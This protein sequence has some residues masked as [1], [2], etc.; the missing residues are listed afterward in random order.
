MAEQESIIDIFTEKRKAALDSCQR[1]E[2]EMNEFKNNRDSKLKDIE[3][4]NEL[5]KKPI[6]FINVNFTLFLCRNR[7]P[8]ENLRSHKVIKL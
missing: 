8:K 5:K 3:V 7:Y 1:I 2:D 4:I 6:N